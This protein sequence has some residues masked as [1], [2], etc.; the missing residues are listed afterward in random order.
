MADFFE[1]AREKFHNLGMQI[2]EG[3]IIRDDIDYQ[4]VIS[5]GTA[6]GMVGLSVSAL[7]KYE[8]EG[9]LIFFRTD[10]GRRLLS[11]SDLRRIKMIQQLINDIGLN[12]EG[13]RRLLALL[14]CW[15]LK[16]C[17]PEEKERC[18]AFIDPKS[19]CWMLDESLCARKGADCRLCGV[20]RYGAY[21][22]DA[23]KSVV[24]HI[25]RFRQ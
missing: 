17:A 21:C 14:P 13:I 16:P 5:I 20:Y 8:R 24:H 3:D 11:Y 7:R 1:K 12:I 6:A 2:F 10:T 4:P 19:P 18:P 15:E 9:L 23:M 25:D 22:A